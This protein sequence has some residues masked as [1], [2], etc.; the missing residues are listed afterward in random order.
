MARVCIGMYITL[1]GEV[2][3]EGGVD[4][5]DLAD[6]LG[7]GQLVPDGAACDPAGLDP[8]VSRQP[9]H[10][11]VGVPGDVLEDGVEVRRRAAATPG[12]GARRKLLLV[13]K[14]DHLQ[15]AAS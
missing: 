1:A 11:G 12:G 13:L 14:D 3:L 10:E 2:V 4:A 7:P 15:E 6:V 8:L 5:D 9:L